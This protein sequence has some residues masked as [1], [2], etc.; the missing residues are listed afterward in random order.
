MLEGRSHERGQGDFA[1]RTP[2]SAELSRRQRYVVGG[3]LA[4]ALAV[5]ALITTHSI[6]SNDARTWNGFASYIAQHGL[7]QTYRDLS[8]FNHP[9]LMGWFSWAALRVSALL[10]VRFISV[11]KTPIILADLA[12]AWLLWLIWRDRGER[13]AAMVA[14]LFSFNLISLLLSSYHGNTDCICA[15]LCLASAYALSREKW[16]WAGLALGAAIN[17]KIVPLMLLPV[18]ALMLPS[19]RALL[20]FGL[21]L[22]ACA[23]TF[24]LVAVKVWPTLYQNVF[25]YNSMPFQWGIPLLIDSTEGTLP[26]LAGWLREQYVPSARFV[27]LGMMVLIGVLQ[28]WRR[29][30]NA[31][32]AGALAFSV[33]LVL[34]PGFGVQYLA[35]VVPLLFAAN[36]R[37]AL[38]LSAYG[39]LFVFLIYY[40]F[41]TGTRPW[42]S[43]FSGPY[44]SPS[45]FFG[46]FAWATLIGYCVA[47]FRKLLA[48]GAPA[49]RADRTR[50]PRATS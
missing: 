36:L 27:I 3:L 13:A 21:A 14:V 24:V 50:G 20:R 7:F 6:G 18:F 11:F 1:P 49:P 4:L 17:V 16:G 15:T 43:A 48:R 9:P 37:A 34:A 46:V 26:R 47:G 19:R 10:H 45:P 29:R 44:P 25:A 35:W 40:L 41:W 2:M 5:R 42:Y 23:L 31:F 33:F 8:D 22:G 38:K 39:G 12:S 28:H 30:L 32:E